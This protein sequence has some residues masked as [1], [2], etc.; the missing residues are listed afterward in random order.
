MAALWPGMLLQNVVSGTL[1]VGRGL[2]RDGVQLLRDGCV[3]VIGLVVCGGA[4]L[5]L[6]VLRL[7]SMPFPGVLL[8]FWA[9]DGCAKVGQILT[10]III[11]GGL[12]MH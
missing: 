10:E 6:G 2:V 12:G 4:R 3:T 5:F 9:C 7:K 11:F 1:W 8:D